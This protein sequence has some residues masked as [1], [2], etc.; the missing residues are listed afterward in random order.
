MEQNPSSCA[1]LCCVHPFWNFCFRAKN[2]KNWLQVTMHAQQCGSI[3]TLVCLYL[4]EKKFASL[5][6]GRYWI[7]IQSAVECVEF[8]FPIWWPQLSSNLM[9]LNWTMP[10]GQFS[11]IHKLTVFRNFGFCE[12]GVQSTRLEGIHTCTYMHRANS[13]AS[14]Y[15]NT[16][17]KLIQL[18]RVIRST[19]LMIIIDMALFVW[20]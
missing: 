14:R 20:E 17:S 8:L 2:A 4:L 6:H 16:S 10:R 18:K 3:Q 9:I 11:A 15:K 12:S 19:R 1:T 13:E 7:K 5:W